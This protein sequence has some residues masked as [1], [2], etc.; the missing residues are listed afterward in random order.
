MVAIRTATLEDGPALVTLIRGAFEEYR[1]QLDPPSGA[2]TESLE[3][4]ASLIEHEHCHV[5]EAADGAL[6]GC[7]FWTPRS[8]VAYLHRLAVL[9]ASRRLGVGSALMEVVE[10]EAAI[11]GF[12]WIALGVRIK[13]PANRRFYEAR[14]Y[15]ITQFAPHP[16]YSFP[17]YLEMSKR[18]GPPVAREVVVE[19]WSPAWAEEYARTAAEV[20]RILRGD[21]LEIHHVGSTAVAGLAAKPTIDL[22]GVVAA[23]NSVDRH[24]LH[25]FMAGWAPLGEHGMPG[26]RFYRKGTDAKHTHHLHIFGQ[27]HPGIEEHLALV[28]YL[29]AHPQH[30]LEYGACKLAL[31]AAHP[32]QI[33][34]YVEGK[35]AIVRRLRDEALAWRRSH[36]P[37]G[38]VA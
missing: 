1:G 15:R 3:K 31:A 5:A 6:V 27:G 25:M 2:L 12:E 35:D 17:T 34:S 32:W 22:L 16:G 28:E 14:G 8:H 9:P 20:Q 33:A 18:L 10:A 24:D 23:I 13:L 36:A 11:A 21:L 30:A 4:V 29:K 7:V 19:D 38:A 37:Q 26:R